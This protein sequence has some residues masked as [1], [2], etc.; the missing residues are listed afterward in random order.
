MKSKRIQQKD[1]KN[2]NGL[3]FVFPPLVSVC[4]VSLWFNPGR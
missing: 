2:R 3:D 1:A 4:S